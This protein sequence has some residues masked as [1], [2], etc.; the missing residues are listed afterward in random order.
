VNLLV[1]RSGLAAARGASL[2]L[3]RA[4]IGNDRVVY[5]P[6]RGHD[7]P[8]PAE[9]AGVAGGR[10]FQSMTCLGGCAKSPRFCSIA[11]DM[12]VAWC[13]YTTARR[14]LEHLSYRGLVAALDGLG[15]TFCGG[16]S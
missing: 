8:A 14:P 1:R 3:E 7:T 11:W 13:S 2:A 15:L 12:T 5:L 10:P 16:T 9:V 6:M 4:G